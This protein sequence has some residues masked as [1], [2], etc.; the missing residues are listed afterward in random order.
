M[1]ATNVTDLDNNRYGILRNAKR[2]WSVGA[3]HGDLYSLQ[4]IHKG[5]V[6]KFRRGDKIV[7]LGNYF[8]NSTQ[9]KETFDELLMTRRKNYVINRSFYA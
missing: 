9:N 4:T 7:Y 5:L 8:G 1:S 3:I 6:S 2:I